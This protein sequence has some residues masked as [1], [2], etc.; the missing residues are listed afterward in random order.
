MAKYYRR[1]TGLIIVSG[2]VSQIT[3]DPAGGKTVKT[4]VRE[5]DSTIKEWKEREIIIKSNSVDDDVTTGCVVTAIGYQ[6]GID[7][8]FASSVTTGNKLRYIEDIEVVSGRVYKAE[9]NE[10]KN[11]DGTQK[12]KRDGTPRKPHFDITIRIPD[13][14]GHNVIH[15]VKIY[16]FKEDPQKKRESE[17]EKAQRIFKNF[18]NK[19]ETPVEAVIVTKPGNTSSWESEFKGKIYQN[20]ASDHLGKESYDFNWLEAQPEDQQ[21]KEAQHTSARTPE[22]QHTQEQPASVKEAAQNTQP[23]MENTY[24]NGSIRVE[25]DDYL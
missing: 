12:L 4:T 17:I 10:E 23:V 11:E 21:S 1:K 3:E 24:G 14:D 20:F 13:E 18:V 6:S 15:R 2:V 7:T 19:D 5:F 25:D 8:I 22:P 16:N 9:L